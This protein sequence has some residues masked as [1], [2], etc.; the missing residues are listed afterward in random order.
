MLDRMERNIANR[1]FC[2]DTDENSKHS[3][4]RYMEKY[5]ET[6][7][8]VFIDPK[9]M[10]P[11]TTNAFEF[12][13][14]N[15]QRITGNLR[16][17]RKGDKYLKWTREKAKENC[18]LG[19]QLIID[20][21]HYP[22]TY[23]LVGETM[24]RD[25]FGEDQHYQFEIPLCKLNSTNK[26][27]L[28]A[29]GEPTIFDMKLTALRRNDGVM[30]KLTAYDLIEN[31]CPC[32][33]HETEINQFI[34]PHPELNPKPYKADFDVDAILELLAHTHRDYA[35]VLENGHVVNH[36]NIDGTIG[37]YKTS[38][39][40]E[41][42]PEEGIDRS[43]VA[44]RLNGRIQINSIDETIREERTF[45]NEILDTSDYTATIKGSDT[46]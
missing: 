24:I 3:Q 33:E 35:A 40:V 26:I 6:P 45:D 21:I 1:T 20:P 23:R 7:L 16:I 39:W 32:S 28:A 25:R 31:P 43:K 10:Q 9:T 19:K 38:D 41:N 29:T 27:S 14:Q 18:S 5:S 13:R 2:I 22:G 34:S 36:E 46:E 4:Y 17:I 11:F 37:F 30:M 15:G 42:A 8:T 44:A 12:Y